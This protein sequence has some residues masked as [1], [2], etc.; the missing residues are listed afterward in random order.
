[1]VPVKTTR[2]ILRFAKFLLVAD[3]LVCREQEIYRCFLGGLQQS[4]VGQPVPTF[5][6]GGDDGV[7]AERKGNA[8]GRSVVKENE[9]RRARR[10]PIA[11]LP[12]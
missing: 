10:K 3:T 8:L 9:H 12:P 7:R 6:L 1:V 5:R 4:T 11:G 2:A